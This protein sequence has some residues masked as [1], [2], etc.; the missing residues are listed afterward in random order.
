MPIETQVRA[1]G[2]FRLATDIQ[3]RAAG[4]WRKATEVWVRSG[5]VWRQVFVAARPV[6]QFGGVLSR[7]DLVGACTAS[8]T[9]NSD[10]SLSIGGTDNIVVDQISGD[11]WY[12]PITAGIGSTP[13]Y[14]LATLQ[15][16]ATPT[17]GQI[18]G[19]P[20]SLASPRT[21]SNTRTPPGTQSSTLDISISSD[22]AGVNVVCSGV[23]TIIA[24]NET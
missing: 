6:S 8:V 21:W 3:V 19:S 12:S 23:I 22:S 5:G 18:G 10:G 9:F 17:A 15:S 11:L 14:I 13:Y 2:A 16:G 20:Q 24:V 4:S 1:A 7:S